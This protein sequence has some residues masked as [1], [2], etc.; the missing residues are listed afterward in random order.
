MLF[1]LHGHLTAFFSFFFFCSSGPYHSQGLFSNPVTGDKNNMTFSSSKVSISMQSSYIQVYSPRLHLEIFMWPLKFWSSQLTTWGLNYSHPSN[2][3]SYSTVT[4][5]EAFNTQPNQQK[6]FNQLYTEKIQWTG[7]SGRLTWDKLYAE[8]TNSTT[9]SS[10]KLHQLKT[11]YCFST[12][13]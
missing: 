8:E 9:Q 12:Q 13:Q 11:F 7:F 4:K 1:I 5:I 6:D 3:G 10:I 2:L